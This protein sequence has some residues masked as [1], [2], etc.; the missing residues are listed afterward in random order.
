LK[1]IVMSFMAALA[2]VLEKVL[3]PLL[4]KLFDKLFDDSSSYNNTMSDEDESDESKATA[5]DAFLEKVQKELP[6]SFEG[7]SITTSGDLDSSADVQTLIDELN[8]QRADM[9]AA[10]A[11]TTK[12]DSLI[13]SLESARDN[14]QTREAAG[15]STGDNDF[16]IDILPK[17]GSTVIVNPSTTGYS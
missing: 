3:I 16:N 10:G 12:V 7:A 9:K 15:T 8:E 11:D 2:P 4:E 6:T 1:E 13:K 17:P 5:T 14:L